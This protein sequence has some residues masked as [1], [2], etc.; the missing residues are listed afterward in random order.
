MTVESPACLAD[1]LRT[2]PLRELGLKIEGSR[3]E[4]LIVEFRR[5]L[6]QVGIRSLCPRVYLSTE[7]GVPFGTIAIGV[8]FYLAHPE[9][10]SVHAQAVGHVEGFDE[11]DI[12]RYL[13]HEMGHVVNYSYK[14]YEE[15]GWVKHFGSITQPYVEEYRPQ[16]FSTRFVRNLPGWYAQKHPD[17]DWAETFAV[18]MTPGRDWQREYGDAPEALAKLEYCDQRIA[19]LTDKPPLV[20]EETVDDDLDEFTYSVTEFYSQTP[21]E[22]FALPAGLDGALRAM[23]EEWGVPKD[24]DASARRIPASQLIGRLEQSLLADVYRW[25]GHFPERTRALLQRLAQRTDELHQ[26]YPQDRELEVTV[27]LTTF[28][29]A[30]AANYVYT[31]NYMT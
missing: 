29:C 26:V 1:R 5:E 20:T 14:L 3:L 10:V 19:E 25:T 28:V 31:G 27:A 13:R 7:W 30:L 15:E 12:L 6:E 16:P 22:E 17:E 4:P 9:L 18:W 11:Q 21:L 2:T 23:F 8:P 24:S